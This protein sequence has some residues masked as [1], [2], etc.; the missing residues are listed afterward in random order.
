MDAIKAIHITS[1][2]PEGSAIRKNTQ[3]EHVETLAQL[4]KRMSELKEEEVRIVLKLIH[5][6]KS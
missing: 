2:M 1:P 3:S 6:A 5:K 4:K